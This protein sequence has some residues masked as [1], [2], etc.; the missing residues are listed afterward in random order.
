MGKIKI[1]WNFAYKVWPPCIRVAQIFG[2]HNFR[3]KYLL[4]HLNSNY[5]RDELRDLLLKHGFEIAL[6]AWHD[7]GEVLSMRKIDR[8]IFQYHVRLFIDGEIRAH[9][10]YSPEAHPINHL[11]ETRFAPE[12]SF[13]MGLLSQY[14]VLPGEQK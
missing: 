12:T 7:P 14:L 2:M 10:E 3:Q 5:N 8:N 4:G 9:H 1:F 13:F 11:M 6:I